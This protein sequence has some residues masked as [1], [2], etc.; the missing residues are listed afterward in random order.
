MLLER[1]IKTLEEGIRKLS[2]WRIREDEVIEVEYTAY[3]DSDL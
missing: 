1:A 3:S 2:K